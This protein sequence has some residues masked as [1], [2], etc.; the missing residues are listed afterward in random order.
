MTT[1]PTPQWTR[2]HAGSREA[3]LARGKGIGECK[4]IAYENRE[5]AWLLGRDRRGGRGELSIFLDSDR[6]T[7]VA[8]SGFQARPGQWFLVFWSDKGA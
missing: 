6:P 8:M 1:Q 2:K 5:I 3:G 7:D 4:R